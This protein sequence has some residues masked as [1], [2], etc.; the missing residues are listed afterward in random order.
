VGADAG[1]TP[2]LV[3]EAG[4]HPLNR[5][6]GRERDA[7][8]LDLIRTPLTAAEVS[9]LTSS[10]PMAMPAAWLPPILHPPKNVICVGRNYVEHVREGAAAVGR[11][12][13]VPMVPVFFTKPHTALIGSGA[14]VEVPRDLASELDYEG[15]LAA[16]IGVG[17]RGI[18][19]ADA[20][21]HVF[22][23]TLLNDMTARDRQ[24]EHRQW[25]L[26][27]GIDSL[28]P[29]GPLVVTSDEVGDP[30]RL[31]LTTTVNGEL[32]QDASTATMIFDVAQLIATLSAAITLEPGDIIATGT[33]AG[34]GL[35]FDPPRYLA[36]GD[37]VTVAIEGIGELT[38]PVRFV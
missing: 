26:G 14:V 9:S 20:L 18:P 8:V 23:Y 19:A 29:C 5:L 37:V 24:R 34:T 2:V 4:C 22:G 38:N 15:E 36:D 12:A 21:D 32:R 11:A 3:D 10:E 31:R 28:A 35:G 16:V 17:G 6:P 7:D 25:F 13:E 30:Q 27:K 1:S 33:P